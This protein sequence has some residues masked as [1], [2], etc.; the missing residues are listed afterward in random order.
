MIL[1]YDCNIKINHQALKQFLVSISRFET[2]FDKAS[3]MGCFISLSKAWTSPESHVIDSRS[4][5]DISLRARRFRS[6]LFAHNDRNYPVA[7][8]S[9]MNHL[10]T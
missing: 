6:A 8:L 1:I 3:M 4:R 5:Y 10:L 9:A 2:S 7:T